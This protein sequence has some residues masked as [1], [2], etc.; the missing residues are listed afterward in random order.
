MEEYFECNLPAFLQLSIDNLKLGVEK[1]EKGEEYFLYDCD[2]CELQS[3]I[4]VAEVEG[5]ISPDQAWFLREKY[6]HLERNGM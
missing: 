6:L 3:D 1:R 5:L 2:Y 4:N